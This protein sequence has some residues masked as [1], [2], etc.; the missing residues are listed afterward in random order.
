MNQQTNPDIKNFIQ[1]AQTGYYPLFYNDWLLD[2]FQEKQ[3]LNIS[4]ASKNV[5]QVFSKL[6]R[7]RTVEKKKTALLGMDKIEREE[8]I[9][10]FFKVVE[11]EL[12]KDMKSLQ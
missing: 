2:T 7:H 1:I 4:K 3:S 10:S 12:L 6:E 5:K 11:H 9:R 8:F